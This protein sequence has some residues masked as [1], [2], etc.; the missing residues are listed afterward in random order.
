MGEDKGSNNLFENNLSIVKDATIPQGSASD[1]E[2]ST[3]I[4]E[5]KEWLAVQAAQADEFIKSEDVADS[6]ESMRM[7]ATVANHAAH[8]GHARPVKRMELLWKC[9]ECDETFKDEGSYISH[10]KCHKHPIHRCGICAKGYT[11]FYN[12]LVHRVNIHKDLDKDGLVVFNDVT[13]NDSRVFHCS[14]SGCFQTCLNYESLLRHKWE[15]HGLAEQAKRP[16]RKSIKPKLR[17]CSYMGCN[18]T[19]AKQSDLTRHIRIHTGEKPFKCAHC[20]A[21][22]AQKYRLVTHERIHTGEKPFECKYCGKRFARGD[23]VQSHIYLIHRGGSNVLD[24]KPEFI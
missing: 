14:E 23:A 11:Q 24:E 4:A 15:Y 21:A 18:K 6:L 19:F 2:T 1:Y 17:M 12:L 3:N 16:Y 5:T 22:F 13:F 9:A 8:T 20:D 7:I 10:Y